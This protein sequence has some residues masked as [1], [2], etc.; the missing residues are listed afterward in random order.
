M[1]FALC[2]AFLIF[3][4]TSFK[5]I[6]DLLVL[7]AEGFFATDLY[8]QC[9]DPEWKMISM[10]HERKISE[11]LESE[12]ERDGAVID[13][14]FISFPMMAIHQNISPYVWPWNAAKVTDLTGNNAIANH[15]MNV[16]AV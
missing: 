13:F 12:R 9:I 16:Y 2:L 11:L 10:L 8:A 7:Q 6:G 15:Q 3:C 14:T 5:L 4:G 1:M